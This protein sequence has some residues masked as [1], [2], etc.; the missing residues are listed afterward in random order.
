MQLWKLPDGHRGRLHYIPALLLLI[1]ARSAL[2]TAYAQAPMPIFSDHPVNGFQDWSWGTHNLVNSSPVHSGSSSISA[3]L[4]AWQAVSFYHPDFSVATYGSLSFWANGGTPGGQRLQV[5]AQF[6]SSTGPA[7][8]V[9]VLAANTWKQVMV[10]LSALGIAGATNFN[11]FNIQLTTS[12]SAGTFFIDDIQ[13]TARPAPATVH[14]GLDTTK[15]VRLADSRWAGFNTAVWDSNF[16]SPTTVSLL[17]EVGARILRFPGGSLSDE[18][19]WASNTTGTN[20]WKW[21]TSFSSFVHVATNI[22]AQAFITV[23]YGSGTA[24]EAAA[25]VRHANVTNHF[26]F[27][28]WEIGNECYGDWETDTNASPHDPFTYA[29]R[30]AAYIQ[31][32]KAV[33]PSIKVGLVSASGE[34]SYSNRYSLNHPAV[35]PRTGQTNYGWTPI[36]L[37]TLKNLG[38]TPDF[39]VEHNY[40]E[41]TDQ[42]SDPFLLQYSTMWPGEAANLRQQLRDY[43][44][45]AAANV[46]LVC[47]ENNS[48]SGAQG[49]QSTSL[50]NGLYYADSLGQLMKTEL[51]SFLWWDLRNGTDTTGSFDPV[52][53]GW[54]T[55]GD[56]G[57]VGNLSTRYP[58]FY[59]AKLFQYL[60]QQGDRVLNPTSDYPLLSVYAAQ[61]AS[62]AVSL[63]VLN[64][65][66]TTNFNAQITLSGFD[67]SPAALLRSF[68]I[69]QDDAARTNGTAVAQDITTNTFASASSNFSF[70]FPALS[71]TLL[72]LAPA[73]PVLTEMPHASGAGQS[74]LQLHGQPNVRYALQ[75]STNLA[76]WTTVW[77][78]TLTG[79]SLD[80]TNAVPPGTRANFW[81]ALWQP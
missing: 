26:G 61:H 65:D 45:T 29:T 34:N 79:P 73:A 40:P 42:E 68:G 50:V 43:L 74:V 24:G 32:M 41:W 36:M 12:G 35:N 7:Y 48:N 47:T 27:K 17:K 16:D 39:L 15:T 56:L 30:A 57:M 21:S 1:L 10:P 55:S 3:S 63:L 11:R 31:Q 76:N 52:L 19:H 22:G 53:Y 49:K 6:G 2:F 23:N 69:P 64:K 8:Q 38:V 37:T 54:R 67:P 5:V 60:A 81:R 66:T 33:D 62:G 9:P 77:T 25:W 71:L 4:S 20:T 14:I 59:A 58:P 78:N 72:T 80:I 75:H 46:E 51:N 13:L 28:Y 44:G 18:Y 70:S